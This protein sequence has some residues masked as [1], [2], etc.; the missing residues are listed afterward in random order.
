MVVDESAHK[1]GARYALLI[2]VHIN[3]FDDLFQLAL[4]IFCSHSEASKVL[5]FND[6]NLATERQRKSLENV[7]SK[8]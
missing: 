1:D 7:H 6:F 8:I 4:D 2:E 3:Q 5:V